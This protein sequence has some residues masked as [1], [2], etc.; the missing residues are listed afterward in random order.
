[1]RAAGNTWQAIGD[2]LGLH[3]NTVIERGRRLKAAAPIKRLATPKPL[4]ISSK[5]NREPLPRFHP[6]MVS[7]IDPHGFLVGL[8]P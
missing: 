5:V 3:R 8:S 2:K 7:L 4:Q 1:M 6:V